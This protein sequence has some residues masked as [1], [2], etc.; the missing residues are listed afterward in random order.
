MKEE[1]ELK[2]KKGKEKIE[3]LRDK[4]QKECIDNRNFIA[5]V[6]KYKS[7]IKNLEFKLNEETEEKT[8]IIRN[9]SQRSDADELTP[10]F[11]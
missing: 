5:I 7:I 3:K 10:R 8:K 11:K 1:F 2:H 9:C 4:M 6:E